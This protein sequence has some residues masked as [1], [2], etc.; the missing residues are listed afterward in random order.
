MLRVFRASLLALL[1]EKG[2]VREALERF[3]ELRVEI[4]LSRAETMVV[5]RAISGSFSTGA[6]GFATYELRFLRPCISREGFRLG[7][8]LAPM[9]SISRD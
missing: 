2:K 9:S 6:G 3:D 4:S 8:A 1:L 7:T 5:A